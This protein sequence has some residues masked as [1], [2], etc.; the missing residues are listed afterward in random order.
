[1]IFEFEHY[2]CKRGSLC[3]AQQEGEE[4]VR[5]NSGPMAQLDYVK[6]FNAVD[7]NDKD[8]VDYSTTIK[9][10]CYYLHIFCWELDRVG[11]V[12]TCYVIV[13]YL[14]TARLGKKDWKIYRNKNTGR[15]GFQIGLALALMMYAIELEGTGGSPQ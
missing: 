11:V 12:H 10:M 14:A 2:W 13:C 6:H 8:S 3:E 7:E 1:M 15:H 4:V 5:Q 9:T